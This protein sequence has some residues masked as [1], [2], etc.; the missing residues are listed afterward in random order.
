MAKPS[1]TNMDADQMIYSCA[2]GDQGGAVVS[3]RMQVAAF[4]GFG[5][6]CWLP[7]IGLV[8]MFL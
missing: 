4:L 7:I 5:I 2:A 1:M 6:V 8:Y 3:Q